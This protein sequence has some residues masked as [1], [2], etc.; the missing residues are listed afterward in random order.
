VTN[1]LAL[2]LRP[3]EQLRLK[4]LPQ[5]VSVGKVIH[6]GRERDKRVSRE[7]MFYAG[8]AMACGV[9]I[10]KARR[11]LS[12]GYDT[13]QQIKTDRCTDV[14]IIPLGLE[15]GEEYLP[16]PGRCEVCGAKNLIVPCRTCRERASQKARRTKKR[17]KQRSKS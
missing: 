11:L 14:G 1:D 8:I 2:K 15:S 9:S 12:L 16:A 7:K 10:N 17:R 4:T 5:R 6:L 13:L 3:A